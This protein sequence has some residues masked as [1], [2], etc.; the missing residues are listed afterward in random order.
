[1]LVSAPEKRPNS[2]VPTSDRITKATRT[3]STENPRAAARR[4]GEARRGASVKNRDAPGEPVNVDLILALSR[5]DGET[6]A[7]R[8]AIRK[9]TNRAD[10]LARDVALRGEELQL[11]LLRQRMRVG[12]AL[13][14]ERMLLEVEHETRLLASRQ[15]LAARHPQRRRDLTR[16]AAQFARR[17]AAAEHRHDHGRKN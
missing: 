13:E 2:A 1:M 3:S 7:V 6:P 12:L 5:R 9:E 16:G 14:L 17:H 10:L 11:G 8:S 4:R 15:R